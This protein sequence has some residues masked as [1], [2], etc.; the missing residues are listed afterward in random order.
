MSKA[1][2][3]G[4]FRQILTMSNLS[5]K[6]PISNDQLEII[7]QGGVLIQG[8]RISDIGNFIDLKERH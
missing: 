8:T 2:L 6:G 3:L 5:V 7:V 4:P 1:K